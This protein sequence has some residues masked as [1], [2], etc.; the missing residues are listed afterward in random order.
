[1]PT[2]DE[3]YTAAID[4]VERAVNA[5]TAATETVTGILQVT[6]D[7]LPAD[8]N[9]GATVSGQ[10]IFNASP[11]VATQQEGDNSTAAANAAFVRQNTGYADGVAA[12]QYANEANTSC[13]QLEEQFA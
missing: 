10:K 5:L 2:E 6:S 12:L 1:M 9:T 13:A 8:G 7:G 11:V 3:L 4:N